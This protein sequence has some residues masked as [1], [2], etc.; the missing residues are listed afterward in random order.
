MM[1][2]FPA[3]ALLGLLCLLLSA[4]SYHSAPADNRDFIAVT[5]LADLSGIYRNYGEGEA[6]SRG[7]PLSQLIWPKDDNSLAHTEIDAIEVRP[8]GDKALLIRALGAG[9]G[10]LREQTFVAG[11]DFKLVDGRI[12]LSREFNLLSSGPGDPLVGPRYGEIEIGLDQAGHGKFRSSFVGG[13]L[14]FLMLPVAISSNDELRFTR[15]GE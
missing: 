15:I 2:P 6:G 4:C 1:R 12:R 7:I 14:I 5:S 13:G 3:R 9:G 8:L 10:T 11:E